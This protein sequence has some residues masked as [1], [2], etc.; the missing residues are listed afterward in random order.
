M[1]NKFAVIG[2]GQFGTSIARTLAE[3]GSEVLAID[4]DLNKVESL[5][6]EVAFSVCLDATDIKALKAQNIEDVDAVEK[7]GRV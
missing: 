3:R 1:I 2:L 7:G 6:D 5:K 4:N